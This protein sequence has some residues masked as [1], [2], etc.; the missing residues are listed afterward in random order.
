MIGFGQEDDFII[1]D[2]DD[3]A[4]YVVVEQ[5]PE[6][7]CIDIK[8]NSYDENGEIIGYRTKEYC[9]QEG[10]MRY[11]VKNVR[12]PQIAKEYNI[13]GKVYVQ[14][15]V[16]KDGSVTD[17]KILRGVDKNLDTEAL[18]V[19]RSLPKFKPGMQRGKPAKVI[20]TIPINFQLN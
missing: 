10:L 15:V 4:T 2:F 20:F 7:P 18:R 8:Y 11:I 14:F 17:V 3:S 13:T 9:G 16:D 6:F 19:I 1:E 5:M 12:Y